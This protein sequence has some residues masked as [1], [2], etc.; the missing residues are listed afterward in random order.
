MTAGRSDSATYRSMSSSAEIQAPNFALPA[1]SANGTKQYQQRQAQAA[2]WKTCARSRSD[3]RVFSAWLAG[4]I[5]SGLG[6]QPAAVS[7]WKW[8]IRP[9]PRQFVGTFKSFA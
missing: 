7:R 9:N 8:R 6:G 5:G 3:A 2:F 1:S 4:S